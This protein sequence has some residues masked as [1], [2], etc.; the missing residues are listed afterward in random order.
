[1][2]TYKIKKVLIEIS[3]KLHKYFQYGKFTAIHSD[4]FKLILASEFEKLDQKRLYRDL[5]FSFNNQSI[6]PLFVEL[7]DIKFDE[8]KQPL[9]NGS[10]ISISLSLLYVITLFYYSVHYNNLFNE[11]TQLLSANFEKVEIPRR[12]YDN[13]FNVRMNLK[14]HKNSL[15]ID[16]IAWNNDILFV[17]ETKIWDVKPFFEHRNVHEYRKRDLEGIVDGTKYT[18]EKPKRIPNLIEKVTYVEQHI[19]DILSKYHSIDEF[20]DH[21]TVDYNNIKE[22]KGLIVTRSYP[23]IKSYKNV[24]II[25]LNEIQDL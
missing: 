22:I 15:E 19:Q 16:T 6:F 24:I 3:Q 10:Y 5:V 9:K 18:R 8:N 4:D 25:G 12:F 11:E 23:P 13:G 2:N 1:M 20:P 14:K 17:V 7:E 21:K